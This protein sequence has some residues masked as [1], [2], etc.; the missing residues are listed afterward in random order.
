M[1]NSKFWAL[2]KLLIGVS[3]MKKKIFIVI[4]VIIVLT[5]CYAFVR[6]DSLEI[7]ISY[8]DVTFKH[9]L[10]R[11]KISE[12]G[13]YETFTTYKTKEVLFE[14]FRN[15]YDVIKEGDNVIK[16]KYENE[17]IELEFYD[18]KF[19]NNKYLIYFPEDLPFG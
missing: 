4:T 2:L 9:E 5:I 13:S 17:V 14:E 3:R 10:I 6:Y 11:N 19:V 8:K 7:S 12:D 16:I 1:E 15:R 18:K